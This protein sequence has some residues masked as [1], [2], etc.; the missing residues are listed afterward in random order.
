LR[1][2]KPGISARLLAKKFGLEELTDYQDRSRREIDK[3]R[4]FSFTK[5]LYLLEK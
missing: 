3:K 4:G 2:K 5:K 1:A